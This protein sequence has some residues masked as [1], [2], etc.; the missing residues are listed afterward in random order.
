MV[1]DSPEKLGDELLSVLLKKTLTEKSSLARMPK[2]IKKK[3]AKDSGSVSDGDEP[4][5]E[6]FNNVSSLSE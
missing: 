4:A 3:L 6:L 2:C 5:S 1:K